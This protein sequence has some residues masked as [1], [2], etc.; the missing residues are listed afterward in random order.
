MALGQQCDARS[1]VQ[2][3]HIFTVYV[4]TAPTAFCS[5]SDS[6]K[7]SAWLHLTD[8]HSCSS[9]IPVCVFRRNQTLFT[10]EL[11]PRARGP[12]HTVQAYITHDM[13]DVWRFAPHPAKSSKRPWSTILST[14]THHLFFFFSIKKGLDRSGPQSLVSLWTSNVQ[15]IFICFKFQAL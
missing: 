9:W 4:F 1:T 7:H 12:P 8:L 5:L 3:M 13:W 15:D 2:Y 6:C 10:S 14:W 11:P